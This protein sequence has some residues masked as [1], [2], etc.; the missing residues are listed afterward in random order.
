MCNY[1]TERF[2][3][4]QLAER[5]DDCGLVAG[6]TRFIRSIRVFPH[7]PQE[8]RHTY[9]EFRKK[10]PGPGEIVDANSVNTN[11]DGSIT[12]FD[13]Q[14]KKILLYDL[15][16]ILQDRQP[17]FIEYPV[18]EAPNLI[19]QVLRHKNEFIVKG[20][21]G[22]M[23]Y[24]FWSPVTRTYHDLYTGYPQ[25][26]DDPETNWSLTDYAARIRL[27]PD[28]KMLAAAT[29]IGGVLELFEIDDNRLNP[30][31]I[32]YFFEPRYEHLEG[33]RPRWVKVV[34]ESIIGFEDLCLTDDAIYGLV[35][36]VEKSKMTA[37]KPRLFR[38]DP[39]GNPTSSYIIPDDTLESIA[40]D[41]DGTIYGAGYNSEGQ[42]RLCRYTPSGEPTTSEK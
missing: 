11:H 24:G 10:R 5:P 29:Y 23:R 35:W 41:D 8:R 30:R 42:Y 14:G 34:S 39:N 38:F 15:I 26:S 12:V 21:D 17:Y 6:R 16:N 3:S 36:G 28:G 25:L 37:C 27:S 32:R 31:A 19:K 1:G 18:S 9:Q 20:N 4:V 22:K 40:V 13:L 7:F 33:A 2:I